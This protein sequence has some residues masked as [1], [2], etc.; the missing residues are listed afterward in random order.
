MLILLRP[1][2]GWPD[3]VPG[4][5]ASDQPGKLIVSWLVVSAGTS[6]ATPPRPIVASRVP[7]GLVTL[8]FGGAAAKPNAGWT[9]I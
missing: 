6:V 1:R 9:T 7:A 5:L 8:I 4:C 2:A 3:P